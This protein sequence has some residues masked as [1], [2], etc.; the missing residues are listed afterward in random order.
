M[1]GA[2]GSH[3]V[4]FTVISDA[5]AS[6][7]IPY[8]ARFDAITTDLQNHRD[9]SDLLILASADVL[10][11]SISSYSLLAAFL[12]KGL[13]LWYEPQMTR[14]SPGFCSLWGHEDD[15]KTA[16][17]PTLQNLKRA[18]DDR[19][20]IPRGLPVKANGRLSDSVLAAI[21]AQRRPSF[22]DL[23]HYGSVPSDE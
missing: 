23:I 20:A 16:S 9:I 5:K 4:Q 22:C 13:Y 7:L 19:G 18:M 10:I 12:S 1:Q 21:V 14:V 8:K 15:Q 17:S 11:C 2:L 3:S 6:D